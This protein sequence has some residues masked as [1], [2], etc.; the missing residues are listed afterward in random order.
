MDGLFYAGKIQS[1]SIFK[2]VNLDLMM[3]CGVDSYLE[4][5][6]SSVRLSVMGYD[7]I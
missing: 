2:S 3:Q 6:H 4:M 5:E 1:V 7:V